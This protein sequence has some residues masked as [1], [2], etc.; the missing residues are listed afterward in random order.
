MPRPR[1]PLISL[2]ATPYYHIVCRCIRRAFLCGEDSV[3]GKSFEHRR[4]WIQDRLFTLAEVFAVDVCAFAVMSNHYHLVLHIDRES[5]ES[6]TAREMIE[7][8]H[9]LFAG[10]PLSQR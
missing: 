3:T 2:T 1:S 4:S 5:A 9:E 8:W 10:N 7:R 6:W